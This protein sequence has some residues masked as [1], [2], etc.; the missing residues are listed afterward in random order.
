MVASR[1]ANSPLCKIEGSATVRLAVFG[2]TVE[3]E[4][5]MAEC[6]NSESTPVT[7]ITLDCLPEQ[8]K[9]RY[10]AASFPSVGMR[11]RA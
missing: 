8:I 1:R 2:P 3:I 9:C 11:K 10:C 4:L 7:R 5:E 6:R